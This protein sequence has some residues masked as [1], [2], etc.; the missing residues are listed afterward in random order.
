MQKASYSEFSKWIVDSWAEIKN[1]TVINGFKA[2]F[3]EDVIEE[4]E[5]NHYDSVTEI[6][7]ENSSDLIIDT[8]FKKLK[9]EETNPDEHID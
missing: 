2:C 1:Q 4:F 7:D 3:G 8:L 5:D 6:E 9:F